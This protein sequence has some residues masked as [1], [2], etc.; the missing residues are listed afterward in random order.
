MGSG[1]AF[2]FFEGARHDHHELLPRGAVSSRGTQLTSGGAFAQQEKA[3][4]NQRRCAERAG[5]DELRPDSP[6]SNTGFHVDGSV[7]RPKALRAR[8][9]GDLRKH[10]DATSAVRYAGGQ[11]AG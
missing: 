4:C 7:E 8:R 5:S 6:H 11:S 2:V 10:R 3:A 1:R 9:P